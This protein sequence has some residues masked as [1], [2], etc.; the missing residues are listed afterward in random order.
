MLEILAPAGN[1]E[2]AK[3]AIQNGA[4]AIY[5]GYTAFSARDGA[6]NFDEQSLQTILTEAHFAGVKV[7]VAMNTI[8]KTEELEGFLSTILLLWNMGVD[9]I[10]MQDLLLGAYV[11]ET[12]PSIVLHASTQAGI[13]FSLLFCI[14]F[15]KPSFYSRCFTRRPK[16]KRL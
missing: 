13:Y 6:E 8:V 16:A 5:L 7:Y 4:N 12:Y 1:Y 11:H 3:T 15:F 9:A 2:C 14:F 10:I